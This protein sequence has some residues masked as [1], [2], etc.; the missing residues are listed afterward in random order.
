MTTEYVIECPKSLLTKIK[1]DILY[2]SYNHSFSYLLAVATKT[3]IFIFSL[4]N[5]LNFKNSSVGQLSNKASKT[6]HDLYKLLCVKEHNNV[7]VMSWT[8]SGR[9]L[10]IIDVLG[11]VIA[12]KIR[13]KAETKCDCSKLGIMKNHNCKHHEKIELTNAWVFESKEKWNLFSA[14]YS[15][16]S[17][18]AISSKKKCIV[19]IL[20]PDEANILTSNLKHPNYILSI[21]WCN[22]FHNSIVT[23]L[24][25]LLTACGDGILRIWSNDIMESEQ[26]LG[27]GNS[28]SQKKLKKLEFVVI[29]IIDCQIQKRYRNTLCSEWIYSL[30]NKHNEYENEW[31]VATFIKQNDEK[32]ECKNVSFYIFHDNSLK[33]SNIPLNFRSPIINHYSLLELN[34]CLRTNNNINSCFLKCKKNILLI[35][36]SF[37]E[38]MTLAHSYVSLFSVCMNLSDNL[39][40][41]RIQLEECCMHEIQGSI[42]NF[43]KLVIHPSVDIVATISFDGSVGIWDLWPVRKLLEMN[44]FYLVM[45]NNIIDLRWIDHD[46]GRKKGILGA[47]LVLGVTKVAVFSIEV[48]QKLIHGNVS[49]TSKKLYNISFDI[50]L[51]DNKILFP[52]GEPI[53]INM[54]ETTYRH[55]FLIFDQNNYFY[56]KD[57]DDLLLITLDIIYENLVNIDSSIIKCL[58]NSYSGIDRCYSKDNLLVFSKDS[59]FLSFIKFDVNEK[60][61]LELCYE[62]KFPDLKCNKIQKINMIKCSRKAPYIACILECQNNFNLSFLQSDST[63]EDYEYQFDHYVPLNDKPIDMLWVETFGVLLRLIVAFNSGKIEIYMCSKN[64]Q[65]LVNAFYES[66]L[67]ITCISCTP[68]GLPLIGAGQHLLLVSNMICSSDIPKSETLSILQKGFQIGGYI[69]DYDPE[70]L[71]ALLML[72]MN[73]LLKE[74]LFSVL[75][76]VIDNKKN[77]EE[78]NEKIFSTLSG[79]IVKMAHILQ[80]K[81]FDYD[82]D[83]INLDIVEAMPFSYH[84][85]SNSNNKLSFKSES[86][87]YVLNKVTS[88][89]ESNYEIFMLKLFK[90][91][92]ID[93]ICIHRHF[94]HGN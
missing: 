71:L 1:N 33:M 89:E 47:I 24:P 29:S 85:E 19:K 80:I 93:F 21:S 46:F 23:R 6:H 51:N 65:W 75:N 31:V 79:S 68:L 61:F 73:D 9:D 72:G 76:Y 63:F 45:E 94:I 3:E 14:G 84:C 64:G 56:N 7:S 13:L 27:I 88:Q 40:K 18:C 10:I 87:E 54:K 20:I 66:S 83:K 30:E 59:N 32:I 67:M 49:V 92:N 41:Q 17:P 15:S 77:N 34:Y 22:T 2:V 58:P 43:R 8:H 70:F 12:Y 36:G 86:S 81:M 37:N 52:L 82:F 78:T 50:I 16:L 38:N 60:K 48:S 28:D 25:F 42:S 26:Y 62:L 55:Y 53:E 39:I 91:I 74:I 90:N 69:K 11:N 44:S 5:L 35:E 4:K 57:N